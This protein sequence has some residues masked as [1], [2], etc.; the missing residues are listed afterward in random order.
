MVGL[1]KNCGL[2][3]EAVFTGI[4]V[5]TVCESCRSLNNQS[6]YVDG[7]FYIYISPVLLPFSVT[8]QTEQILNL[9]YKFGL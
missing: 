6:P 1:E 8:T 5:S 9:M 4:T 2:L 7:S 3:R